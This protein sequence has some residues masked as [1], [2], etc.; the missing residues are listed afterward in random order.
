MNSITEYK[1]QNMA[2]LE[3][4]YEQYHRVYITYIYGMYLRS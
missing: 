3:P 2:G 4:K 1:L